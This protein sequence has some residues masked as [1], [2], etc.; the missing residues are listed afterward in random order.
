MGS[1]V[2]ETRWMDAVDQAVLVTK[3]DLTPPRG[4]V[5]PIHPAV[6]HERSARDQRAG[7]VDRGW[8]TC[9]R[10]VG[11]RLWSR[12]RPA[13]GGQPTGRRQTVGSSNPRRPTTG[14]RGRAAPMTPVRCTPPGKSRY[15][16]PSFLTMSAALPQ[17]ASPYAVPAHRFV[18]CGSSAATAALRI[19]VVIW[20]T[21][22]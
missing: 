11:G 14:L 19:G 13:S 2:D 18:P 5:L 22:G 1:L 8:A 4:R 10:P 7:R 20:L 12:R 9:R 21:S 17:R 15:T 16:A 6:Q 3:G